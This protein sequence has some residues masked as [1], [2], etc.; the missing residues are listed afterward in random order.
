MFKKATAKGKK[1]KTQS[2]TR[3]KI[4]GYLYKLHHIIQSQMPSTMT[5]IPNKSNPIK[6]HSSLSTATKQLHK[7]ETNGATIMGLWVKEGF[8]REKY[9]GFVRERGF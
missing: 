3:I 7:K 9:D 5:K 4:H 6:F 1:I 8:D 2:Q